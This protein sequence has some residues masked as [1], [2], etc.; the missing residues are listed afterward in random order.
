MRVV[1]GV[2]APSPGAAVWPIFA[3]LGLLTWAVLAGQ[4]AHAAAMLLLALLVVSLGYRWIFSWPT[5]LGATIL[6]IMWIP[7]RRFALPGSLPFSLE[8]YRILVFAVA[9]GWI[10]SLLLDRKKDIRGT[11]IDA[12]LMLVLLVS[13]V[14][15]VANS[16][17]LSDGAV[18]AS[19]WKAML[20]LLSYPI[21]F[22]VIVNVTTTYE[23]VERLVRILVGGGAVVAFFA[24]IEA[25]TQWNFF[26]HFAA[27][28]P[29]LTFVG[30]DS[31]DLLRQGHQR[32]LAS[33]EHPIALS[34]MLVMLVPLAVALGNSTR[35]RRWWLAAVLMAM[36]SLATLSRTG[37]LMFLVIGIVFVLL[38]PGS[39]R[40]V[41]P[42]VLPALVAVHFVLPGTIGSFKDLFFPSGGLVAEQSQGSVGSSRGASFH[43][44]IPGV[45]RQPLIGQGFGTRLVGQDSGGQ[46][47]FIVDDE[48]L[49]TAME[50]GLLGVLA[51]LWL[52]VR[53]VRRIGREAKR[54]DGSRG[55][56][57]T[58]LTA[59]I[60]AFAVGMIY[61][62][63][64]SFIQVTFVLFL[65]LALGCAALAA[66]R[67]RPPAEAADV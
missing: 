57:L 8:P 66:D 10:A 32:V 12:P 44:A 46:N 4:H 26:D 11:P 40:R 39:I 58:A 14:S 25:R 15:I 13:A 42:F 38:R 16:S 31:G 53:S 23:A 3:G 9:L 45:K 52:F 6:V 47:S 49:G 59:G 2:A 7:I 64:F 51:W 36:A 18:N 65:F 55:L 43:A 63:A 1:R 48:W 41:I 28:L 30:S 35:R 22:Y 29:G 67:P 27:R 34:A 60:A 62:D 54:D 61:Y 50:T 19:V 20:F 24:L 56:L 33:A 21:L 17:K 5:Q 37:V